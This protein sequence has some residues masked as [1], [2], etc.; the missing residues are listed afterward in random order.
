MVQMCLLGYFEVLLD[1][2]QTVVDLKVVLQDL[3]VLFATFQKRPVDFSVGVQNGDHG[4]DLVFFKF[5]GLLHLPVFV[6]LHGEGKTPTLVNFD[7]H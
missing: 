1:F 4:V 3:H 6:F 5:D 2:L 7:S